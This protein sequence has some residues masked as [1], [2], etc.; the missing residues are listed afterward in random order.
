MN[1]LLSCKEYNKLIDIIYDS[2]D[3]K[4]ASD[5]EKLIVDSALE[6]IYNFKEEYLI[7]KELVNYPTI[8]NS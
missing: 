8:T 5:E 1:R 7:N 2:S 3:Y 4:F 6:K